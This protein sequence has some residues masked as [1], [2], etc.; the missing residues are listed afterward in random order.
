MQGYQYVVACG[1]S[2]V[3]DC[4]SYSVYQ[5]V[6]VLFQDKSKVPVTFTVFKI[7]G[8]MAKLSNIF[9]AFILTHQG[10][11]MKKD[12]VSKWRIQK[13][14]KTNSTLLISQ[15]K[16][17]IQTLHYFQETKKTRIWLL[18]ALVCWIMWNDRYISFVC[19]W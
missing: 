13:S 1:W 7:L 8:K 14:T 6:W 9:Q 19:S 11:F 2:M 4:K 5:R 17:M 12:Q 16:L 3:R 10:A 15:N 18:D